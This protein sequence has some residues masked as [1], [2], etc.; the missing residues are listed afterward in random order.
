MLSDK[1]IKLA[2]KAGWTAKEGPVRKL[3]LVA[4][5]KIKRTAHEDDMDKHLG[6]HTLSITPTSWDWRSVSGKNF[7][8]PIRD[9][10]NC[11]SCV[12]FGSCATME[13]TKKVADQ[14][15]S[16]TVDFSEADLFSNGGSC[17][18][19]WQLERANL[20]LQ[21]KGVCLEKCWPYNG[22]KL[23]CCDQARTK[24]VSATRITSDAAA[25]A[26][27]SSN[28][29]IQ[30]A[31][32]VS[33]D[34]FDYYSGVYSPQYGDYVGGHC[35]SAVGYNDSGG[36]WICKNSWST[37]WGESGWFKI[38]YGV[39]GIFR[40]Y[41]GYGYTVTAVPPIPPAG[42]TG[43]QINT[44]GTLKA[45]IMDSTGK[46]VGQT[47]TFV[48]LP[49]GPY[50]LTVRKANY[51]DYVIS[52]TV[53]DK[54]TYQTTIT[55]VSITPVGDITLASSGS[56]TFSLWGRGSVAMHLLAND[57][58][59]GLTSAM[60][61]GRYNPVGTFAAGTG[62]KF[63]LKDTKGTIHHNV[64]V[65]VQSKDRAWLV[66]LGTIGS[67]SHPYTFYVNFVLF[68]LFGTL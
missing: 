23:A 57:I 22:D 68:K 50:I 15:S 36:Y 66:Y 56:V 65:N 48:A 35:I 5:E 33:S 27:I 31:M 53:V 18:G 63:T 43:I 54:Q 44:T 34:F 51:Q 25:K 58:D 6:P 62:L 60:S 16:T 24:I 9:Q 4:T 29:S 26:W 38:A 59:L 13:C 39:C 40:D 19:G 7:T 10:G 61:Y 45:D 20:V 21:T 1:N 49:A 67:K 46:L 11:G 17:S 52:F 30:I 37:A 41:A 14:N 47:D 42:Q 28:G 3:G 55:L 12:A 2:K 8:T 32:D 64:L